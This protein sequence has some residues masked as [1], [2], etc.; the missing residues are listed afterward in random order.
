MPTGTTSKLPIPKSWD[1]FEDIVADVCRVDFKDAFAKRYGRMGQRQNGIDIYG[2]HKEIGFFGVQCKNTEKIS[3]EEIKEEINKT[4]NFLHPMNIFIIATTSFRDRTIQDEIFKISLEYEKERQLRIEIL[5]WEDISLI[6]SGYDFLMQKH[7]S[8][9]FSSNMSIDKIKQMI[10]NSTKK[11]WDFKDEDATYTFKNDVYLT[12]KR[13]EQDKG[14]EFEEEWISGKFGLHKAYTS[15]HDIYYGSSLIE[16][17]P[18]VAVDSYRA[19]IP[20]PKSHK[21]LKITP[22][23]YI[24]G[25][26]VNDCYN[27]PEMF[28]ENHFDYYLRTLKI[29]IEET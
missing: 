6:I 4:T 26:I 9:F 13:S 1:E 28:G 10:V 15:H 12:I 2:Q 17:I 20:Y 16:R 25:R 21:E 23:Q 18:M 11:D 29:Q 3:I 7:Y 8:E 14:R 27:Y 24:F 19:Y 22:F 5:F